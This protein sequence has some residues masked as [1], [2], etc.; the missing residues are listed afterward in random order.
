MSQ[1]LLYHELRDLYKDALT[2]LP[3]RNAL[4]KDVNIHKE[5]TVALI[6]IDKF[7]VLNEL[8][9]ERIGDKILVSFAEKMKYYFNNNYNI[10][11]KQLY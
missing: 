9:G 2:H 11:K 7:S 3:T 4:I 6:D 8:Y 5:T 10:T 1:S